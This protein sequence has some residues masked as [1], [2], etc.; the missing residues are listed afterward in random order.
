MSAFVVIVLDQFLISGPAV[1]LTITR[2]V[3]SGRKAVLWLVLESRR[4]I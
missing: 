2:T 3:Q 1:F 4:A